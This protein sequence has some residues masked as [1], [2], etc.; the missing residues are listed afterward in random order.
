MANKKPKRKRRKRTAA[1][2]PHGTDRPI[3]AFIEEHRENGL[4]EDTAREIAMEMHPTMS[5]ISI[6]A[7]PQEVEGDDGLWSPRLH[8][9]MHSTLERQLVMNEPHGIADI[10]IA[11]EKEGRI[12]THQIR[13]A[14]LDVFAHMLWQ[15]QKDQSAFDSQA[16]LDGIPEAY[17]R[18]CDALA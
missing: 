2:S 15:S 1:F 18:F 12:G 6:D 3:A 9:T 11:L 10:A 4:D 5:D 8:I 16:Y 7:L 17:Q 14:I 13:H